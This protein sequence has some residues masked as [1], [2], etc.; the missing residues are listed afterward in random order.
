MQTC[1]MEL[2]PYVNIPHFCSEW[3]ALRSLSVL[4]YTYDMLVPCIILSSA[5][6]SCLEKT[7]AISF[8]ADSCLNFLSLF[9]ECV[10]IHYF[11]W[12]LVSAFT[13]ETQIS[14]PVAHMM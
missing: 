5:L 8:L 7:I 12:S 14:S 13:N 9:G 4:E 6:L 10:C 1:I 2:T 3:L 11:E